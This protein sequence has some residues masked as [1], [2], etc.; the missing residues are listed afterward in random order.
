MRPRTLLLPLVL[1]LSA[2]AFAAGPGYHLINT[3]KLGGDGGWDYLTADSDARR[4]YISRATRVLV[5]DMDSGKQVGEIPDTPGV[6]GIA[7]DHKRGKG[8]ISDGGDGT[9]T[10]FDI[11][12]LKTLSKIKVGQRPDAILFDPAT[13]HVFTFNAGT[14]DSSVIDVTKD[15]VV[16]TI[17]L[18]GKPEFAATDLK[19]T[20]FVNM[21]DKNSLYAIDANKLTVK[22][23]WPL[24]G[25]DE[26][27]GLAIDRKNRRLFSGCEK[28]VAITDAD[29]G[30]QVASTPVGEG[31]DANAYDD[32]TGLAFASAGGDAKLTVVQ[33]SGGD[34]Y[35]VVETPTTQKGARTMALDTK[36]HNIYLVTAEFGPRPAP[37][38]QNPH[39]RPSIVPGSFVVLVMGK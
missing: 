2:A 36:T 22:S 21:E 24:P 26:P 19:G 39:P 38:A 12:S 37:T 1:L 35:A 5:V 6:H 16:G 18:G 29:S 32:E 15:A 3:W 9:V 11:T 33:S 34:K 13:D 7:L 20:V 4:L 17:P 25:C 8:Y 23:K 30:K 27:S 31:V 28:I 14:Q 10:V